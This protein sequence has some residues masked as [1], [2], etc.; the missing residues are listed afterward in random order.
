M[1]TVA[2]K[3]LGCKLNQYETEAVRAGVEDAG[4]CSV[5][6]DG[7]ADFYVVNTCTVTHR[8]DYKS[9]QLVRRVC[10]ERP[11][12][13]VVVTGCYADLAPEV[14]APLGPNVTVV[15]NS[16]KERIPALIAGEAGAPDAAPR[17]RVTRF[18][19][20]TRLFL[21]VQDG[22]DHACAYCVVVAARGPSRSR[23]AREV[24]ADVRDAVSVGVKEV[25]L[26]GVDL[27]SYGRDGRRSLATLLAELS[28]LPGEF[29]LRLSSVDASDFE[30]ALVREVAA[31]GRV[32][33]HVHL[34]LQSADDGV[35][36]RMRRRYRAADYRRLCLELLERVGDVAIGADVIAGLPGEDVA[37]FK[38]TLALVE[39][40][41]FAY[42]HVFPYSPRPGTDAAA[43]A[44]RAPPDERE[45][46][47]ALLRE[48]AAAKRRS[49]ERRFAG[50]VRAALVEERRDGRGGAAVAL[51]DNYLRVPLRNYEGAGNVF[52]NAKLVDGE[53]RLA[54]FIAT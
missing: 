23:P 29:R 17:R 31:G 36:R 49:Y 26:V 53:G 14:F 28:A 50:A 34:P 12:A 37:A 18:A 11:G 43:M 7:P 21:K 16:D 46:R 25:V 35:L 1:P 40:I 52:A 2:F 30:P 39:E 24:V 8:S 6:F 54:A 5:P 20:K 13:R 15:P 48:L 44:D 32:C 4:F 10:R 51:T 47:A 41:P 9:R 45:R 42:L 3:T 19:N 33:P 27:G 22:C 38:K